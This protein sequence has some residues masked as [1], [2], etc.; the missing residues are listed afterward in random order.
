[1]RRIEK[2][3]I[4]RTEINQIINASEVCR[5][6]FAKENI[7]YIIPV[8]FGY[9]GNNLYLHTA[10]EGKKIEF[11]NANNIVSFEF[12]TDIKTITHETIGCKWTTAYRSVIGCGKIFE[13]TDKEKMINA[14]N[15]IMLH[16][17]GKEW[18]FTEKMLKNMR[19]W[20][21]EIEEITGKKS[22]E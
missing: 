14:L 10:T 7:P 15:Q 11:I 9:D 16:Y 5:I 8:S 12:D 4:E 1:M 21:I 18:V 20:K 22:I 3:I 19:I 13:I 17:S 2:R 6:A